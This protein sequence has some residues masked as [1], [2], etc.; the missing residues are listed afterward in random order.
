MVFWPCASTNAYQLTYSIVEV[1]M[2]VSYEQIIENTAQVKFQVGE[3]PEDTLTV[4]YYP[5]R[6]TDKELISLMSFAGLQSHLDEAEKRLVSLN[7]TLVNLIKDW[8]FYEDA[9]FTVKVPIEAK[10]MSK[11]PGPLRTRILFAI[12][13]DMNP[14]ASALQMNS[15]I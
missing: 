1:F 15:K 6:V 7:E 11:L 13:K 9:K 14:E 4:I 2:P 10:R 5:G 3:N 12:A 8:D